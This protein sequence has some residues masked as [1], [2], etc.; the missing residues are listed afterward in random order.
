MR[1][2]RR[3]EYSLCWWDSRVST[4]EL[5]N[6]CTH[7]RRISSW[8]Y[9]YR[10][11]AC[12]T[13]SI[14][15]FTLYSCGCSKNRTSWSFALIVFGIYL[16]ITCWLEL[17]TR[18]RSAN[19]LDMKLMTGSCWGSYLNTGNFRWQSSAV[20]TYEFCCTPGWPFSFFGGDV[21]S[22]KW[23]CVFLRALCETFR[24]LVPVVYDLSLRGSITLE[25]VYEPYLFNKGLLLRTPQVG[26]Q[27]M[28]HLI[29]YVA[30][31]VGG[32]K[33]FNRVME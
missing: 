20:K 7:Q 30:A 13:R 19:I 23:T 17:Q 16:L 31:T 3:G 27:R 25:D 8:A 29:P 28:L 4:R 18:M 24:G 33:C 10:E 11:K 14:G 9:C 15:V 12:E 5:K 2:F 21:W 26:R 6:T 32:T 22:S 1:R